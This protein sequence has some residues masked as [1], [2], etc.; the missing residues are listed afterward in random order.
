MIEFKPGFSPSF[1]FMRGQLG[2]RIG[3]A[4]A[5]QKSIERGKR[6]KVSIKYNYLKKKK[7]SEIKI[8][9]IVLRVTLIITI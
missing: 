5:E 1:A 3:R 2:R 8:R 7:K 6:K 4:Y 9:Y